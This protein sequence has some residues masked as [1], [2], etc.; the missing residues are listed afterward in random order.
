[1]MRRHV[2]QPSQQ[3]ERPDLR[4]AESDRSLGKAA[5]LIG[6]PAWLAKKIADDV[7]DLLSVDR[8]SGREQEIAEIE[9]GRCVPSSLSPA[10]DACHA[11]AVFAEPDI[12]QLEIPMTPA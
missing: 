10:H 4:F 8:H 12:G 6:A 1:M 11:I 3:H 2:E 9:R 7:A 5:L